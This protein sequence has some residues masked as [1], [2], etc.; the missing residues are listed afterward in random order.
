MWG[1]HIYLLCY[2]VKLFILGEALTFI[3]C[4]TAPSYEALLRILTSNMDQINMPAA[5]IHLECRCQDLEFWRTIWKKG[6]NVRQRF[7]NSRKFWLDDFRWSEGHSS[8]EL[9]SWTEIASCGA[10]LPRCADGMNGR[11]SVDNFPRLPGKTVDLNFWFVVQIQIV[12]PS[13]GKLS[14]LQQAKF[15]WVW[16][17]I[18]VGT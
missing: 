10:Y 2:S 12:F 5:N 8:G 6:D 3:C 7:G 18:V 4:A 1:S 11:S 15:R 17:K 13:L 16:R 14:R 9:S